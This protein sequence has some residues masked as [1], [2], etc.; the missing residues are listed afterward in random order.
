MVME[1]AATVLLLWLV[2]GGAHVALASAPIRGPLSAR[3]GERGFDVLFSSIAGVTFAA[4]VHYYAGHRMDGAMGPALGHGGVLRWMAMGS[5]VAG[6]GLAAAA[7]TS[8]SRSPY[9]LFGG[10]GVGEPRGIERVTRHGF[11]VGVVLVAVPHALL[12]TRLAGTAFF[13]GFVLLAIVGGWHQDRKLLTR[14]G[15]GYREYLARTS[16]VPF[17]AIVAGRQRLVWREMP[18]RHLAAGALVAVALRAV[19]DGIFVWGGAV[20]IAAVLSGALVETVRGWRR[21]RSRL[22][23]DSA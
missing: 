5:I 8:Y 16:F 23:Q 14:R 2:F 12:A 15:P 4:L 22:A 19:H 17:A 3:L 21:A 11:L 7:L 20:L 18:A 9:A 10:P 1:P 13:A 6:F